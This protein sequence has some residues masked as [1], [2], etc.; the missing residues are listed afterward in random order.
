M[1]RGSIF[2]KSWSLTSYSN[3]DQ[4]IKCVWNHKSPNFDIFRTP[5]FCSGSR[6]FTALALCI[7]NL[8]LNRTVWHCLLISIVKLLLFRSDSDYHANTQ[9]KFEL[10]PLAHQLLL[11]SRKLLIYLFGIIIYLDM[12]CEDG[13]GG[14]LKQILCIIILLCKYLL[15]LK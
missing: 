6:D 12:L 4:L 2:N 8:K 1:L 13:A 9:K 3:W 10:L 15:V 5:C 14:C 7:F 11:G